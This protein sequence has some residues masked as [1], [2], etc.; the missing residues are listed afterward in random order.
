VPQRRCA[1]LRK[2]TRLTLLSA[3]LILALSGTA[4]AQAVGGTL[5]GKVADP[6]GV[7][8]PGVTVTATE[9]QTK[10]TRT[11]VTDESGHYVFSNLKDGLYRVEME[12]PGF[13]KFSRDAVEVKAN[14]TV[15][16]D[17]VLE[18]AGVAEELVVVGVRGSLAQAVEVK[19]ESMPIVDAIVAEDIG[20]FPD[21]N[22]VES[23][24]RIPGVQVTNRGGGEVSTVSIRGLGD[25]T[26]TVN[27]R[28]IFTSSGRSV[29]LADI[30]AT[31]I[32]RVDVYK[33]RSPENIARGIAGGIDIH[34]FRPFDFTGFKFSAQGRGV[35]GEQAGEVD[36]NL[37]FLLSDRWDTSAGKFGA[38]VNVSWIKTNWLDQGVHAGASVPFRLPD[39]PV[40]PLERLFPPLWQPGLEF[41][42]PSAAGSKLDNGTPY[43]HGRDAMFQPHVRGERER[44]AANLSLQWAPNDKSEYVFEAFYNG[45]RNTQ[46]NSLFF[47]F[48]DW[49]GAVD[50]N[51]PVEIH[52][53]TNVVRSRFVNFPYEFISGDVLEQQTDSYLYSLGGKWDIGDKLHVKSEV[54]YQ[55]S[56]FEDQFFA[57]RM[58]KVSPR[59]FVDFNTGSGVP[60]VQFFDDPQTPANESD[61]TDASQWNLAQLYDNGQRDKGDAFTWTAD[62]HRDFDSGWI[63]QV[64]FGLR[65]DVRSAEEN[66]YFGSDLHCNA[67]PGCAGKTGASFPGLMGITRNHFD[68]QDRVLT[69]WAIPTQSGLLDNQQAIRSAW[70]YPQASEKVF[71]N[72][73]N[74]DEK[75]AEAYLQADFSTNRNKASGY[76]D[77]RVGFRFLAQRADMSF[78]D[79]ETG[80]TAEA[81]N[82]NDVILPSVMLRWAITKDLMARGSYAET[83]SL[84]TFP[85]LNPYVQYFADVTNI[86]YGTASGGNPDLKP[87][88]SRNYDVSLEWYFSKGSVLYGTWFKRDIRNNIAT[89][90]N[91]AQYNDPDDNPDRGLYDYILTQPDN[92]G[93]ATLDG[94]EFGT[95]WFPKLDGWLNG[96]GIQ[97]SLT[98]LDSERQE[99]IQDEQGNVV[100]VDI[101]DIMGVSKTSYSVMLAYDRKTFSARLSYFWRDSFHD[102]NEAA[103]FAN[104]LAIWKSAEESLD[105]QATWRVKNFALT[106]DAVNLTAPVFHENYG[107]NPETFNF[108]NNYFS[109]SFAVGVRYQF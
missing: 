16:V 93:D 23:M 105:F 4:L 42:L 103:L 92:T 2:L 39:D 59:L 47:T 61:L 60:F 64:K 106:F 100:G 31:L 8:V 83:F 52:P 69:E 62:A 45:Y 90:R 33:T 70:G 50:R 102:R 14:S 67:A 88:E 68:G 85:Q 82:D 79:P 109:R 24:Q 86:G 29:A 3:G 58:D 48:V 80:G 77:G 25:V 46:H 44:P 40:A 74:I 38:L 96:I 1:H 18:L 37:S 89:Y 28:N 97:G 41:G 73:F 66:S 15:D 91:V 75:Q 56:K 57:L 17:V 99:P 11:A 22:V 49:W 72:E 9:T 104:P 6:Q 26:T 54:V 81:S 36:P 7:P 63:K 20:K 78:P 55:Q 94:F 87:I 32:N 108:L 98:I 51:D 34:T 27:G 35:Y 12:L 43:V 76:V 53:G 10:V 84:P 95:T 107:D 65:Y 5:R 30:P 71:E 101:M 21:A 19:R 13:K